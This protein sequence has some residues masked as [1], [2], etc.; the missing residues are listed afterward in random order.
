[1]TLSSQVVDFVRLNFLNDP[2]EV[3]RI[4]QV[5]IVQGETHGFFMRILIKMIDTIGVERGCASL[6]PV[7]VVTFREQ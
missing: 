1:M 5:P 7:N 4:R 2:D 3:R 6:D